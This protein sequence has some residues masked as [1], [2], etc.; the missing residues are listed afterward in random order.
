MDVMTTLFA[1][2]TAKVDQLGAEMKDPNTTPER[3]AEIRRQLIALYD[4]LKNYDRH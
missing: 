1:R 4:E 3:R 2:A